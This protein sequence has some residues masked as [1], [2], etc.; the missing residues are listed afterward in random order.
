VPYDQDNLKDFGGETEATHGY[1]QEFQY[2]RI[3]GTCYHL[4]ETDRPD[5]QEQRCRCDPPD[6]RP[7]PGFD[8]S[9]RASL[10]ASAAA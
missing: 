7:W 5:R 2:C 9:E 8:I 10:C 3:C 4:F 1:I 6:D